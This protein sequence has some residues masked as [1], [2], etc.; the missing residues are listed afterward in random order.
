MAYGVEAGH[1][2]L[3]YALRAISDGVAGRQVAAGLGAWARPAGGLAELRIADENREKLG[4]GGTPTR[5]LRPVR[6]DPTV[7][8]APHRL[9]NQQQETAV[10]TKFTLRRRSRPSIR[11]IVPYVAQEYGFGYE[12]DARPAV[13][14]PP[15]FLPAAAATPAFL[16]PKHSRSTGGPSGRTRTGRYA[17]IQCLAG[18]ILN[19][20]V[21]GG[22]VA[23]AG[24]VGLIVRIVGDERAVREEF[25]GRRGLA[26]RPVARRT[27]AND[28]GR[29]RIGIGRDRYCNPPAHLRDGG[30][31]LDAAVFAEGAGHSELENQIQVRRR[32]CRPRS[33]LCDDGGWSPP[34]RQCKNLAQTIQAETPV[35]LR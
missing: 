16:A 7:I 24:I 9:D 6:Y 27:F 19:W 20:G 17:L 18:A 35:N 25:V 28:G 15:D 33:P 13:A 29:A 11:Q 4:P 10:T 31:D 5:S 30:A 23:L 8:Q 2:C 26:R 34:L 1:P 22:A 21:L 12:L 32:Q 14:V 3:R